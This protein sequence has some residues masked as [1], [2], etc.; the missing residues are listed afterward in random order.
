MRASAA[1]LIFATWPCFIQTQNSRVNRNTNFSD[2]IDENNLNTA[3]TC[4]MNLGITKCLGAFG[5]WQAEKALRSGEMPATLYS[6]KFSWQYFKNIS[7]SDL[8][9]KLCDKTVKLLR[10]RSLKLNL[11]QDYTLQLAVKGNGLLSVDVIKNDMK[12][13]ARGT[14][15]KLYKQFYTLM[16]FIIM[17]GLIMSAILPFILPSLKM[18]TLASGMLNNMALTGAVFTLLRNNAFNDKYEKKVIYVNDGYKNDAHLKDNYIPHS[19]TQSHVIVDPTFDTK[20]GGVESY[21]IGNYLSQQPVNDYEV[22]SDWLKQ[23]TG[24]VN[25]VHG[26]QNNFDDWRKQ[27]VVEKNM[28]NIEESKII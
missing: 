20:Y 3:K 23:L 17:P 11:D 16:P 9:T 5:I 26:F 7:N 25:D 8:S 15:K 24:N 10:R 2:I 21:G 6:D 4:V 28:Q 14:V 1:I 18:M 22:N 12:G 13:T 27:D 19:D